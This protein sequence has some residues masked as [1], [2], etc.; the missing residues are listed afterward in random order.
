MTGGSRRAGASCRRAAAGS[1]WRRGS[2]G[3]WQFVRNDRM[4][5][6]IP[7]HWRFTDRARNVMAIAEGEAKRANHP[8]VSTDFILLGLIKEGRG[9]AA[10]V[11]K[12]VNIDQ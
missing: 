8:C 5:C 9:V 6:R 12:N 3:S 1:C 7:T 2:S 11:L 4:P 10:N